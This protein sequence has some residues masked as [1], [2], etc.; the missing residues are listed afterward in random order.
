MGSDYIDS[1]RKKSRMRNSVSLMDHH[2]NSLPPTGKIGNVDR[3]ELKNC[4]SKS[5]LELDNCIATGDMP[6]FGYPAMC[7]SPIYENQ[8][9]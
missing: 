2:R 4:I 5:S 6:I 8:D 3:S 9:A 1:S 7:Y